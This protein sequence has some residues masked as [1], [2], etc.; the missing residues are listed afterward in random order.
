MDTDFVLQEHMHIDNKKGGKRMFFWEKIKN[1]I[2]NRKT[3][4]QASQKQIN[5]NVLNAELLNPKIK[6]PERTFSFSPSWLNGSICVEASLSFSFFLF[7]FV[8]VFFIIISFVDFTEDFTKLQ[9]QGK[10]M[11]SCAYV[12]KELWSDNEDLIVL[13]NIRSIKSPFSVLPLPEYKIEARCVIKPWVGYQVEKIKTREEED[14][15]VYITEYGSVYHKKRDCTHLSLSISISSLGEIHKETNKSGERYGPCEY[16]GKN[17][18]VTAVYIT[19]YGS[20]YHTTINCRG[21]KRTIKSVPLNSVKGKDAC[22]K[23]GI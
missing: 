9:Q 23:C 4:L 11:A 19:S 21:L 1:I 13:K 12:T 18:F 2:S 14:I 6:E 22:K 7:F 5:P 16:C 20:K 10:E 15:L 8:N 3:S 17:N